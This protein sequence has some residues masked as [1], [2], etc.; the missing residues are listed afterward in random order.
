MTTS[1]STALIVLAVAALSATFGCESS[2]PVGA[3]SMP[4]GVDASA[5]RGGEADASSPEASASMPM[6][7]VEAR[8]IDR[9]LAVDGC[10]P[11]RARPWDSD[12]ECWA[13]QTMTTCD[14]SAGPCGMA[15][16]F[17]EGP[18][19]VCWKFTHDCLPDGWTESR[20]CV[21]LGDRNCP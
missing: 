19:G 9:C 3:G 8:S 5:S 4:N 11:Q 1:P 21:V 2:T 10:D 17:A 18:D 20:D 7:C 16:T 13:A 14:V 15:I 12:G 6:E